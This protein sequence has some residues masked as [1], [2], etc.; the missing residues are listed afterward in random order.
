M[1]PNVNFLLKVYH[2]EVCATF[3][4]STRTGGRFGFRGGEATARAHAKAGYI[5]MPHGAS[6]G[7]PAYATLTDAGRAVLNNSN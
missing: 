1:K 4:Y 5:K 3:S 6:L 7:R 2:G